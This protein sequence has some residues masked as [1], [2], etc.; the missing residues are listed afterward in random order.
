[1]SAPVELRAGSRVWLDG[2]SWVIDE[3]G[4]GGALLRSGASYRRVSTNRLAAGSI[5]SG[6]PEDVETSADVEPTPGTPGIE[7]WAGATDLQREEARRRAEYARQVLDPTNP[8]TVRSV[9]QDH[10]IPVRSLQRWVG[11]YR[12]SGVIGLLDA[13]AMRSQLAPAVDPR[14]DEACLEVLRHY[15]QASTPT[16]DVVLDQTRRL[17]EQRYPDGDVKI[18]ARTTA[19]RRLNALAKGRHSFGSAKNRRSVANRP[20]GPY[21]RRRATRPGEFVVLDTTPLDVFAM[22]PLTMRWVPVELTVAMDLY[23]RCILGLT[24][25]AGS[26][27]SADV[28]NVLY[29]CVA[30]RGPGAKDGDWPFHGVPA[31]LLVGTEIPDGVSQERTGWQPACLPEAIIVDHGK[32]YLSEHTISACARL[33]ITVQPALPY[34]PTDKPTVERFFRTIREGLLQHLPGYKG[35]DIY[36]RGKGIEAQAFYY[37]SEL[38]QIIREWVGTIYHHTK[39][40]G[41]AVSRVPGA[42][43]SPLEMFEIGIAAHGGLLLPVDPN[44]RYWFLDVKW[45]TVQHYG[46]EVDGRCYDGEALNPYRNRRSDQAG[47]QAGKWAIYV[48]RHDVRTV[49]F[50]DP[51]DGTFQPLKWEHAAGLDE[52][53]SEVAAEY[54]KLV[55]LREN[56][57][58]EPR[59]AVH[60]LLT[61][62]SRDEIT[63]RREKSVARRL[64][65]QAEVTKAELVAA[66]PPP[67]EELPSVVDLSEARDRRQMEARDDVA[68]LF[69]R[70][71]AEHPDADG[72]EVFQE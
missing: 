72:L 50:R 30:P 38:E 67:V 51:E 62:W 43:I 36:N 1:M 55:A 14:W 29:Q 70:Y 41:L 60:G 33:G 35:P 42:S 57:H 61:S 10:A 59:Q 44:L 53:F 21:G 27:T 34:T 6:A 32:V 52:P 2:S 64:A 20:D 12:E 3:L 26:T 9:A 49:W 45:R 56:R 22:E 19:Y 65:A 17:I 71:Y 7:M 31:N 58:V 68:D 24:L 5:I 13:R 69:D 16:R 37:V 23:S 40:E 46:V 66:A 63:S 18:P 4:A 47:P 39:H 15:T 25:T 48:D 54:T 11:A 8:A 28:A